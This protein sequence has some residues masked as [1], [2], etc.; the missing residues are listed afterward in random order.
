[1]NLIGHVSEVS[2]RTL[3]TTREDGREYWF[4]TLDTFGLEVGELVWCFFR[5][6]RPGR[7]IIEEIRTSLTGR[8]GDWSRP[9]IV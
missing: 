7:N 1:M 8:V 2:Y 9:L 4:S 6:E 5:R 3:C